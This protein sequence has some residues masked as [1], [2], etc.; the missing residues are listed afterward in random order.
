MP[1][2][3]WL[4]VQFGMSSAAAHTLPPGAQALLGALGLERLVICTPAGPEVLDANEETEVSSG[5][6]WC[7]SFANSVLPPERLLA[8]LREERRTLFQFNL[9]FSVDHNPVPLQGYY[10]R[11]PPHLPVV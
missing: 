9:K 1:I 3:A 2:V 7:Q 8:P 11:A 10:S 6:S 5:C 4:I